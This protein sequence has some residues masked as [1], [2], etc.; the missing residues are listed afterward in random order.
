[1]EIKKFSPN[2]LD[3]K[4]TEKV[5]SLIKKTF[6][7]ISDIYPE[8]NVFKKQVEWNLEEEIKNSNESNIFYLAQNT[9]KE[10]VGCLRAQVK[11]NR[12]IGPLGKRWTVFFSLYLGTEK[13]YR[14]EKWV[15]RLLKEQLE[16]DA[17]EKMKTSNQPTTVESRVRELNT[18]SR[19]FSEK[20]WYEAYQ[21]KNTGYIVYYKDY[22]PEM[23]EKKSW[24]Q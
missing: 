6:A 9:K 23:F 1:M 15:A 24:W 13:E 14:G 2:E 18:T 17:I 19:R 5:A 4:T 11:E 22:F 7:E 20:H 12:E 21:E 8:D 16:K 10:I 3:K